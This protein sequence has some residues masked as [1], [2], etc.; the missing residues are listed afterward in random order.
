MRL[1]LLGPPGAGKGTQAQRLEQEL[2]L[3]HI[4]TGDIFRANI[5]NKTPLGQK[6]EAYLSEG[7]LVPDELTIDLIW[8]RLEQEADRG[9]LLDG[10][11]RTIPQ[12]EAFTRGLNERGTELDAAILIDVA[13]PVLVQRLAGRRTCPKCGATYHVQDAPPKEE[14]IC[15]VCGTP[16]VQR[17]DDRE[18][19]V[20]N[21]IT[22]YQESTEPLIDY[23]EQEG[24]LIRIDGDR[25][26]DEVFASIRAALEQ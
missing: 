24:K 1:V 23:Y 3:V 12:A 9:Y 26:A 15:D 20:Q 19:T 21:R 7:K 5:K 16:L 11:P 14:G 13:E 25:S 10:F 6:V 2:G 4:S 22:V 8:D 18:E 17:E